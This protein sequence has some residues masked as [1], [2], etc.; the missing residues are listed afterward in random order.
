M[1]ILKPTSRAFDRAADGYSFVEI[2]VVVAVIA[3]LIFT[4]ISLLA[5]GFL[6]FG[7]GT[8]RLEA[9]RIARNVLE[10]IKAD[11]KEGV[12][13]FV[14][15]DMAGTGLE[16][17]KFKLDAEGCP[18][19][20]TQRNMPEEVT[21]RYEFSKDARGEAGRLTRITEGVSELL[22]D[23][24]SAVAFTLEKFSLEESSVA[25]PVVS[26]E[27]S[28]NVAGREVKLRSLVVP[29]FAGKWAQQPGWVMNSTSD[30]LKYT[31]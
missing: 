30:T 4:F 20:D 8:D 24:A 9:V 29:R 15:G 22:T 7:R 26:I 6:T 12:Y 10:T 2:L 25:I 23:R 14:A 19:I 16:F 28:T 31:F 17:K 13:G 1:K 11:L 5:H 21:V 18:L 3:F 27:I